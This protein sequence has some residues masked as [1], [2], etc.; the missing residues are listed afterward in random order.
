MGKKIIKTA[1]I[2]VV[3]LLSLLVISFILFALW[4]N[5]AF[6]SFIVKDVKS[7]DSPDGSYCLKYQQLGDPEWPFGETDV[8]LSLYNA[9]NKKVNSVDTFIQDDGCIASVENVKSI[10]WQSDSVTVILQASEMEDK[11][12]TVTYKRK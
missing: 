4:W 5:G 7:F 11:E 6:N 8:R 2:C 10:E 1:V 9:K 12:V 3:S